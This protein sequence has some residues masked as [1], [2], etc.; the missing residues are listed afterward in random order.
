MALKRANKAPRSAICPWRVG[1]ETRP[2]VL[3]EKEA[4][5]VFQKG[6]YP[7]EHR[8]LVYHLHGFDHY[9]QSLVLTED[10][11][12]EFL[13]TI[14]RDKGRSTDLVPKYLREA[15][16]ESSLLLLGYHLRSWDFRVLFWGLIKTEVERSY[17]SI[18]VQLEPDEVDEKYLQKYLD[19]AKFDVYR[20]SLE[21]YT[22]ELKTAL[23]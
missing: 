17:R 22:K 1:L 2:F 10:D 11:H 15:L 21:A 8:P 7:S 3:D 16:V 19:E 14:S 23:V 4:Q 13:V 20:G 6:Y 5:P 18:S 9:P 12:L